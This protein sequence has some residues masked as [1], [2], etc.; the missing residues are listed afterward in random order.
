MIRAGRV[1]REHSL[2]HPFSLAKNTITEMSNF[3]PCALSALLV[4][5]LSVC[6]E[7]AAPKK[8]DGI[9]RAFRNARQV[10]R[11]VYSMT[12]NKP[13]TAEK[14][15][16]S[17]LAE[18]KDDDVLVGIEGWDSLKW[19]LLRRHV[20]VLCAGIDRPDMQVEGNAAV[21]KIAYNMRL[22]KLLKDYMEHAVFAVEAKRIGITVP[23]ERFEEYRVKAREGYAQ[24]G[25][26]G[27][28]LQALMDSGESFYEH[29]LTNALYWL[30]YKEQEMVHL[31]KTDEREIAKMIGIRHSAN[32]DTTATN[33]QKRAFMTEILGKLKGGM[34][35]GEAAEQWSESESSSTRGVVMDEA[36]QVPARL[37]EGDLPAE[38]WSALS[39][40]KDG[41]TS[42]VVDT[43]LAW[44]IVRLLKRNAPEEEG[45]PTVEIAQI[46]VEKDLLDPEF[47]PKQAESYIE[48]IKM[49]ALMKATFQELVKKVKIDSRIP[50]WDS[51]APSRRRKLVKRVK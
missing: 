49:Q 32:L 39:G 48:S 28:A 15:T 45:G 24:M 18:L 44:Y 40:L 37:A 42:G 5:S 11:N 33:L 41:E 9:S 25:E 43:P 2:Y 13:A 30:A 46:M 3:L 21:K 26:T 27:K 22:R 16:E 36:D 31:C 23:P 7:P 20:E 1:G 17:R 51:S 10:G 14:S 50:L 38:V 29:N 8:P 34:D 6:A 12:G 35:F 4:L 47:S 19:G